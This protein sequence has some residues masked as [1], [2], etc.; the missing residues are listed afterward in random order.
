MERLLEQL[1][2]SAPTSITNS[3][4][5]LLQRYHEIDVGDPVASLLRAPLSDVNKKFRE[6][7]L[8][9]HPDKNKAE[10]AIFD[11][12]AAIKASRLNNEWPGKHISWWNYART[13][14]LTHLRQVATQSTDFFKSIPI[15]SQTISKLCHGYNLFQ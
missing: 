6:A 12:L 8:L 14:D 9:F 11:S 5:N 4:Y 2:D 10:S 1:W 13:S 7:A 3:Y 15:I